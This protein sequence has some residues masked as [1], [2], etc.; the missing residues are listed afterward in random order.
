[1]RARAS[2]DLPALSP[3]GTA[4]QRLAP[5]SAIPPEVFALLRG[6]D[7]GEDAAYLAWQIAAFAEGL[8]QADRDALAA[9]VARS[10]VAVAQGST[11][12]PID[13]ESK[14]L[15]EKVPELCGASG[16]R[17]PLVVEGGFLYQQKLLA[18][19]DRLVA[20][21]RARLGR[22][23]PWPADAI[24]RAEAPVAET[25]APRPSDE[26]REAVRRA[27]SGHLAVVSGGPGTG[28]TTIVLS[29]ARTMVRLGVPAASIA[30]TAPTGRAASR[31][32]EMLRLGLDRLA[33][34]APEDEALRAA[35][36][37]AETLHRL[38]GYSP[39]QGVFQHHEN[40]RLAQKAVIVDEGSMVDL[41]LMERLVRSLADDAILVLLGD[42]HQ[43]PSVQAGAVFRDLAPLGVSLQRSFRA[44]PDASG[45]AIA[46]LGRH[47]NAGD[48]AQAASLVTHRAGAAHLAFEGVELIPASSREALL[49]RWYVDRIAA[50]PELTAL[51]AEVLTLRDGAFTAA[52]HARIEALHR[53]QQASRI[54]CVT[55]TR[56]TG[57]EATNAWLHRRCGA[58]SAA[59][60]AGEPVM[61][62]R[63]DY[64]RGLWNG[65]QGLVVRVRDAGGPA[66]MAAAFPTVTGFRAF[67]LGG[68]GEALEVSFAMTVHK[69]QGSE[70]D[71]AALLLP[72]TPLPLWS[73]EILY[74]ALTRCRRS[75]VLC[76]S[77][78]LL[79]AAIANPLSRSSGVGEKLLSGA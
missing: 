20:A 46:E 27:L 2:S 12:L 75:I 29:L 67:D 42:A 11:R 23:A 56:P 47:V 71:V 34:R 37:P 15:L 65:D 74:T 40:N 18:S 58:R 39:S 48:A 28:K 55:R 32:G 33:A 62:L 13:A 17:R 53:H 8:P 78:A 66:R 60:V 45:R 3:L 36:P 10:L 21:V 26:Q 76:G 1:M 22:P 52:D 41:S 25:T 7:L 19:E 77:P 35:C 70:V 16:Q 5:A 72:E 31:L 69:A 4:R 73:R 49:E 51:A 50:S 61:M 68:M 6:A 30:L 54:L 38:L 24:A 64:D 59:P 79:A 57:V 43:L 9:L 14:T 44:H 63:N